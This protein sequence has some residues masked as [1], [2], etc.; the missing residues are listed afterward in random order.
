[1]NLPAGPRVWTSTSTRIVARSMKYRFALPYSDPK[2]Y[3]FAYSYC[4]RTIT[5]QARPESFYGDIQVTDQ[6]ITETRKE[7]YRNCFLGLLNY[8][9]RREERRAQ[10][11][12]AAEEAAQRRQAEE[13]VEQKRRA[14]WEVAQ[15]RRAEEE[16]VQ[17]GRTE[18]E[19]AQRGLAHEET[20]QETSVDE[21][22]ATETQ[23]HQSSSTT[24][25]RR[26]MTRQQTERDRLEAQRSGVQPFQTGVR[27]RRRRKGR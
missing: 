25:T 17:K 4:T 12:R 8:R 9:E 19:Q 6:D 18:E 13:E 3:P 1:M 16:T 24:Q 10:E 7:W 26:I 23:P 20:T 15:K 5:W 22:E 14:E 21:P 11:R 27:K 2:A